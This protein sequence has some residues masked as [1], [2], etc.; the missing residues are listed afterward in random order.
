MYG[1]I[2]HNAEDLYSRYENSC[3]SKV[4]RVCIDG[5]VTGCG[6]CVGYC[7]YSGHP[8]FLTKDLREQHDCLNRN[9]YHY[10]PK[11]PKEKLRVTCNQSNAYFNEIGCVLLP[12]EGM[13]VLDINESDE[14]LL[15]RYITIT[16]G[17]SLEELS[18]MLEDK[19]GCNI[20]W[21]KLDYNFDVCAK[22]LFA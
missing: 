12:Y 22:L 7:Q 9:C 13:K 20:F 4:N 21:E 8:G 10:V 6:K 15:L 1:A 3:R 11:P 17:Y 5:R 16:N 19:L 2:T 18:G 14:G